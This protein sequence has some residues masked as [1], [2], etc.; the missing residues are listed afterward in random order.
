[1]EVKTIRGQ[2]Y[3]I[4]RDEICSGKYAP[5][6]RL[7]EQELA[8]RIGVSRSPV[9]EA[10]KTLAGDGLLIEVPNKG[11]FTKTFT[12]RDIDEIFDMRLMLETY[13]IHRC[14]G[15]LTSARIQ[16]LFDVLAQLE[17]THTAGDL[18]TY[19]EFDET[20][21]RLLVEM[22]ENSL[23]QLTYERV[24][25]MNQQFRVLSLSSQKRFD[26]SLTEHS[27]IAEALAVRDLNGAERVLRTHLELARDM[28]KERLPH[29]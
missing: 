10:L 22:S 29:S 21:H 13:S 18:G 12:D 1:M 2:V 16:Q 14:S 7:Q 6:T 4:L 26:E 24:R 3:Q 27:Q 8:E 9:R 25:S 17:K 11:V 28:I 5:G 15:S 23:V 20:F 19:V